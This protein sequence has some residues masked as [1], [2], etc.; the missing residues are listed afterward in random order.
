MTAG[1][2]CDLDRA[3]APPL[4][5]IGRENDR[6]LCSR[7]PKLT[8][9]IIPYS[10][11]NTRFFLLH[12]PPLLLL[13]TLN[14]K[15]KRLPIINLHGPVQNR[16]LPPLLNPLPRPPTL[17]RLTNTLLKPTNAAAVL[18]GSLLRTPSR[19]FTLT[20]GR[21]FAENS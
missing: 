3:A 19:L 1:L 15:K 16:C 12:F 21:L 8:S 17:P 7:P 10:I 11:S 4:C 2:P 13:L 9:G 6:D 14:Q 20:P 5:I 18:N